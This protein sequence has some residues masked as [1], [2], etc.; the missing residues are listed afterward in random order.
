[1]KV[2][3]HVISTITI[4]LPNVYVLGNQL[5]NPSICYMEGPISHQFNWKPLVTP[6]VLGRISTLLVSPYP[7]WYNIAPPYIPFILICI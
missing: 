1:M 7:M 2:C 4:V 5:V 3:Q 6:F